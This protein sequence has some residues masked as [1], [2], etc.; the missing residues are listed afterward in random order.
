[1]DPVLSFYPQQTAG[2]WFCSLL[3]RTANSSNKPVAGQSWSLELNQQNRNHS[4]IF[5]L[6]RGVLTH[7]KQLYSDVIPSVESQIYIK[8]R[9]GVLASLHR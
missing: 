2:F 7:N 8:S 1:M 5:N 6:L 9:V 4:A 3:V